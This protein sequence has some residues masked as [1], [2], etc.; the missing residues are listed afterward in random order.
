M[1]LRCGSKHG[2]KH[3]YARAL[4]ETARV[5]KRGTGRAVL[6]TYDKTCLLKVM[7]VDTDTLTKFKFAVNAHDPSNLCRGA[8]L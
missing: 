6:L 8:R 4:E 3:L 5:A 7:I 2:N 1:P